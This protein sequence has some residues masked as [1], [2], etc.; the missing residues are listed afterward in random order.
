MPSSWAQLHGQGVREASC[1]EGEEAAEGPF[2]KCLYTK[3]VPNTHSASD[4]PA[5]GQHFHQP[6]NRQRLEMFGNQPKVTAMKGVV[7]AGIWVLV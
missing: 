1:P 7:A 3:N 4:L 5:R 6:T 2:T